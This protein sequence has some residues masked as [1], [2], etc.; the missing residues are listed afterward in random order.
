MANTIGEKELNINWPVEEGLISG[1]T[2]QEGRDMDLEYE[3]TIVPQ[4]E[5]VLL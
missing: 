3:S 2:K 1:T 4:R 5:K